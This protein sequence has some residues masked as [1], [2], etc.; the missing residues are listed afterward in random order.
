MKLELLIQSTLTYRS[1]TW[2]MTTVK[3]NTQ[4]ILKEDCKENIWTH[5]R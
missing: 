4:N 1:E 3:T 2:T 5:E